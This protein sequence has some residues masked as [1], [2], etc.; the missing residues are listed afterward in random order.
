MT[1]K[2]VTIT[3]HGMVCIPSPLRKKYGLK[4]GNQVVISDSEEGR[5]TIIPLES[6]ES[7][8]EKSYTLE[9]LK[10]ELQKSRKEEKRL[11]E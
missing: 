5:I 3:N 7:I 11:E 6:M 10:E 2:I 8:R 4:D 9:E 1:E